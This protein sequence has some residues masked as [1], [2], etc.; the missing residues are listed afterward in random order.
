VASTQPDPVH[1]IGLPAAA[2]VVSNYI[3]P[4]SFAPGSVGRLAVAP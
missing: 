4:A 2:S 3:T 1:Q